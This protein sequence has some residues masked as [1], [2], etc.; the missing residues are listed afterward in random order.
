MK[1]WLAV[2]VVVLMAAPMARADDTT[3]KAKVEALFI[4]MHMD[5]MMSQLSNAVMQQVKQM[6]QSM[7][8]MDKLTEQQK[9]LIS[10]YQDKMIAITNEDLGWKALEPEYVTLYCQTYSEDEIDGILT[11][12]KSPAGQAMLDKT[13]ELTTG[14]MKIAQ[15]KM[16]ILQPKI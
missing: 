1:R 11:F 5:R 7:P 12:Y 6:T 15:E 10:S 8:G 4:A 16:V 2:M 9:A 13:P 3:K 14:G